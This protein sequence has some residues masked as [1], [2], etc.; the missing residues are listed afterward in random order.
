MA[1]SNLTIISGSAVREIL[2]GQEEL[3]LSAVRG[4]YLAHGTGGTRC[5]GTQP[6]FAN[7]GSQKVVV[8]M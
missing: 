8:S 7:G 5:P 2:D 3:V 1:D 4:A 6:L